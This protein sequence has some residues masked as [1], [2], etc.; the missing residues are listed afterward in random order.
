M[1]RSGA[2]FHHRKHLAASKPVL[3]QAEGRLADPVA[4]V[5]KA[6]DDRE[7]QRRPARPDLRIAVPEQLAGIGVREGLKFRAERGDGGGE[8]GS[9]D[10]DEGV[11]AHGD[12][13]RADGGVRQ[14][15]SG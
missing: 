4:V 2:L 6:P 3:R 14:V 13:G 11:C 10:A 5:A 12:M 9:G 7:Q 15:P 1:T 8:A